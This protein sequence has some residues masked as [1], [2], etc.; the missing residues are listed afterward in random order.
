[1]SDNAAGQQFLFSAGNLFMIDSGGTPREAAIIQSA[2]L[3]FSTS[4]KALQDTYKVA[5]LIALADL[6]ISG[7]FAAAEWS[8]ETMSMGLAGCGTVTR[9]V[10]YK[11]SND[12]SATLSGTSNSFT[13]ANATGFNQDLGVDNISSVFKLI[14][15][16][17]F[18]GTSLGTVG[19]VGVTTASTG[20]SL[21]VGSYY[22]R[23]AYITSELAS[24]ITLNAQT[25]GMTLGGAD[26]GVTAASVAVTTGALT[27]S[28]N[29]IN[30]TVMANANAGGYAWYVGTASGS[31]TL[32]EVTT[33]NTISLSSLV[34]GGDAVVTADTSAVVPSG[35]YS[36]SNGVY[37]FNLADC[38]A[39]L[40][41]KPKYMYKTTNLGGRLISINNTKQGLATYYQMFLSGT[42]VNQ[43]NVAE[44]AN[45]WLFAVTC[46]KLGISMKIGDFN[47]PAYEYTAFST[48]AN[49][50]GYISIGGAA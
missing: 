32:Q 38:A 41:V 1:M 8:A 27:G 20:G 37:T 22:V 9:G 49:T 16:N 19:T 47:Y 33:T 14:S 31:E 12:E 24:R 23:C 7:K 48:A 44:Q 45:I 4:T 2:E 21:G 25:S 26:Y 29:L 30:A 17:L 10:Q 5:K 18:S 39:G 36:V 42:L 6:K 3:D 28:T 35:Y 34:S 13:V 46:N 40:T 50:I 11:L 15:M 43:A